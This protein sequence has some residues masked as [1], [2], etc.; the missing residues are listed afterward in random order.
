MPPQAIALAGRALERRRGRL[1]PPGP[2]PRR[3]S[4]LAQGILLA[5]G[6]LFDVLKAG[7]VCL[8]FLAPFAVGTAAGV[9]ASRY[10]STVGCWAAAGSVAL[11]TLDPA[12]MKTACDTVS[13]YAAAHSAA[14]GAAAGA[15]ATAL[16]GV[17]EV[18]LAPAS[19]SVEALG[20]MLAVFIGFLGWL[21]VIFVLLM[22]GGF[23]PFEGGASHFFIISGAFAASVTPLVDAFPTFTPAIWKVTRDLRAR[24]ARA[25]KEWEARHKAYAARR[26][27]DRRARIEEAYGALA[28]RDAAQEAERQEAQEAAAAEEAEAERLREQEELA[29]A[30][31]ALAARPQTLVPTPAYGAPSPA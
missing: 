5:L 27:A 9:V 21:L 2:P 18:A 4:R 22:T 19:A 15:A 28:A 10:A 29:A 13:A 30:A 16:T 8:I 24:D 25:R 31:A 7:C 11:I 23:N 20:I 3:H 6:G 14:V 17:A 12:L 26:A 1:E